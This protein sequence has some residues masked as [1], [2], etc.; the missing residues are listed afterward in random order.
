MKRVI[1]FLSALLV[2]TVAM[3]AVYVGFNPN[4]GLNSQQGTTVSV[5]TLPVLDAT[6]SCG[7]TATV[8]AS[9]V[10]GASAFQFTSNSAAG[11]C[12]LV[13]D[14]PSAAPNGYFCVAY[15]ETTTAKIFAQTAHS[16][17]S[18]TVSAGTVASNDKILIEVNGF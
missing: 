6:T 12:T 11:T 5:G 15:D 10:G 13:I 18:C 8:Q 1:G 9:G 16:T 17:T 14:F 3:A 2:T 4:T 7:T